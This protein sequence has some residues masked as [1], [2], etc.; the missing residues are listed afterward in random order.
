MKKFVIASLVILLAIFFIPWRVVSNENILDEMYLCLCMPLPSR[1]TK[2]DFSGFDRLSFP[3]WVPLTGS[4]GDAEHVPMQYETANSTMDI[5]FLR[6]PEKARRIAFL[7]HSGA[8]SERHTT[9]SLSYNVD[10]KAIEMLFP[11]LSGD[12][13]PAQPDS[14]QALHELLAFLEK[15]VI[16]NGSRSR[17][18]TEDYGSILDPASGRTVP[19][20]DYLRNLL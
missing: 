4:V 13:P 16:N 8:G 9:L 6:E 12:E 11:A 5:T 1:Y 7:I 15:W 14:R 10:T 17:F 18:S 2:A 20:R 3:L 19:L